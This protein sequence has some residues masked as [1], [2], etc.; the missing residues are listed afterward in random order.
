MNEF[1]TVTMYKSSLENVLRTT[2]L[3]AA[4]WGA[5]NQEKDAI[6]YSDDKSKERIEWIVNNL[7]FASLDNKLKE[8]TNEIL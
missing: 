4:W 5:D 6:K 7:T 3:H 2:I 1:E 8:K